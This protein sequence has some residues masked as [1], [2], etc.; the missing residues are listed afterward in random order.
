MKVAEGYGC[1]AERVFTPD[2]LAA[3]IQ[4]AK[5]AGRCYVIDAICVKQQLCDMG[6][7]LAHIKSFAPVE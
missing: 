3:A 1:I 6:N 5:S 4:R 7:D 2:D